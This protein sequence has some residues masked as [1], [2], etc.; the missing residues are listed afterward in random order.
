MNW[1]QTIFTGDLA[2]FADGIVL[3]FFALILLVFILRKDLKNAPTWMVPALTGVVFL[4]LILRMAISKDAILTAWPYSR[5]VPLASAIAHGPAFK[6]IARVMGGEVFMTDLIF[7]TNFMLAVLSPLAVFAHAN[8]LFKDTRI[9]LG[10]AGL[11]AVYPAHIAFSRSDVMFIQSIALSSLGFATIYHALRADTRGWLI[12]CN[13]ALVPLLVVT[14]GVRPLNAIYFPLYVATV[15]V[16]VGP[17]VSYRRRWFVASMVTGTFVVNVFQNLLVQSDQVAAGLGITTFTNAAKIA[18]SPRLNTLINPT[19]TPILFTLLAVV[20]G[21]WLLRPGRRAIFLYLSFWLASFFVAHGYIWPHTV[22]TQVRY[23]LHLAVPFLL[24]AGAG[25]RYVLTA[26]RWAQVLVVVVA[27]VSPFTLASFE[28]HTDYGIQQEFDFLTSLRAKIPRGC[29]VIEFRGSSTLDVPRASRLERVGQRFR[30]G[31][32]MPSWRLTSVAAPWSEVGLREDP[33][34]NKIRSLDYAIEKIKS[35]ERCSYFYAG[36]LC[37]YFQSDISFETPP[38]DEV[39]RAFE[40]KE[41]ASKRFMHHTY[42]PSDEV[43]GINYGG[44]W[45]ERKEEVTLSLYQIQLLPDA[46]DP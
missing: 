20:G 34:N 43:V 23:H 18:I 4:G 31:R 28:R 46:G 3:S 40:M 5:M 44:V 26:P 25:V 13:L 17:S 35:P 38:C 30:N 24:F 9:A 14:Y 11:L 29:N 1:H 21:L 19:V 32:W 41:V 16:T 39:R 22:T 33:W 27:L 7:N 6:V 12:T 8:A 42:D 37:W 10:T 36:N 45:H 15:F 2:W